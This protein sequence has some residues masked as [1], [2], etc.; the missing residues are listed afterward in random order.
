MSITSTLSTNPTAISLAAPW[1]GMHRHTD[2]KTY[3]VW[4]ITTSS[5]QTGV[6]IGISGTQIEP[7]P[8]SGPALNTPSATAF[9]IGNTATNAVAR[10]GIVPYNGT[11]TLQN[12][13]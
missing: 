1:I 13:A 5:D 8:E 4:L 10:Y 9:I 12:P 2:N 11:V 3:V 6:I 7:E